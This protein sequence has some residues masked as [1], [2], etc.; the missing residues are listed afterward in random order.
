M[1]LLPCGDAAVLLEVDDLDAVVGW[2]AAIEQ[3]RAGGGLPSVVDVVPAARTVLLRC[4]PGAGAVP[5]V[6]ERLR[7]MAPRG[8]ERQS[9]EL[10]EIAVAYD[11]P[12]LQEVADLTGLATDEVVR[13]HTAATWTVAFTGFAPG[14][15]YLVGGDPHLRVARRSEPRTKVPA[16]SVGLAG[17]FSGVYPRE[18][19]GGWR[20]IGRTE[21]RLWDPERDPPAL[22][23]PGGR[24]R[25]TAVA[26]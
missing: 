22:L 15:G 24:V 25:F 4:R 18:S 1:R 20:L 3:E 8:P 11:G 13:L 14:F 5:G 6:A 7:G 26:T 16:G 2:T 21:A 9:G 17:E 10:V 19:P 12:D 23:V